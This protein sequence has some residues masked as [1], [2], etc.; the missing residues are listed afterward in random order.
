MRVGSTVHEGTRFSLHVHV[1]SASSPEVAEMRLFRDRLKA[2]PDL[3]A[4]YVAAK[5]AIIA[6]GFTD[7]VDY[8]IRKEAFIKNA[9]KG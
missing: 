6:S 2:S 9:L 1:I 3:M 4:A 5:K 7:S 8:S